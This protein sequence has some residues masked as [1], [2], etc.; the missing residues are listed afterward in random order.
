MKT[1]SPAI[2]EYHN[3][4]S[5]VVL[6]C[7]SREP[8]HIGMGSTSKLRGVTPLLVRTL[9]LQSLLAMFRGQRAITAN[10][11]TIDSGDLSLTRERIYWTKALSPKPSHVFK[12]EIPTAATPKGHMGT[13]TQRCRPTL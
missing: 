4:I 6:G 2:V 10:S 1:G 11:S 13:K 5:L 7:S 3:A 8:S 12:V 9:Q